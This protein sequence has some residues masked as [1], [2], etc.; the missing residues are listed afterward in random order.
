MDPG[1]AVAVTTLS[2]KYYKNAQSARDEIKFFANELEDFGR[3]MRKFPE[4]ADRSSKLPM[5]ASLDASIRQAFSDLKTLESK[6]VPGK[7]AKAMRRFGMRAWKWPFSKSEVEQWVARFQR[8][9]EKANFA[10]NID[11]TPL[12]I[13]VNANITELQQ[14]QEASEQERLLAKLPLARNASFDS[15]DRQHESLCIE[16]TRVELLQRLRDWGTAHP[17]P[18]YWLSGM[19]GT[20]KSTIARTLAHYFQ[21]IGTLGGSFFFSRSSGEAN[22]AV[23]FVGTL[24]RHLA[25]RSLKLR[26]SV[27][28]AISTHEDVTRQGLRNQW[29]ELILTPLSSTRPQLEGRT[30]LNLVI[31]ALDE[32]GSDEDIETILQLCVEVKD[33]KEVDLGIFITSRPEVTIRLGF[34]AIPDIIHQKLDLRDMPRYLVEHDLSVLLEREFRLISIKHKLPGWPKHEEIR[35]LVQQSDCLF[36]YATTACRY[37]G[38]LDKDPEERLSEVLGS[39]STRGGNTA[40][41]DLMY[42]QVLTSSLITDRS[43]T[44]ITETCDR[45]KQV[46]GSIVTLFD[47]FSIC[48]L[49]GL[50]GV[51]DKRVE[52]SLCRLHSVL[53]IPKDVESSIRLLHPSFRDYLLDKKRSDARFC[54]DRGL[55]HEDLAKHCLRVMSTGLKRNMGHLT[56]PGSPPH[57]AKREHLNTQ[58]PKHVQYACQYWV[59]HLKDIKADSGTKHSFPN[60]GDIQSFFQKD[61][62]HWLEAMSLMAKMS[63]AVLLITRLEDLLVPGSN[64]ILLATVED[65]RRFIFSNRA[66]IEKAPLQTYASALVFCPK[67]S[68]VR[69]WY[70]DQLPTWLIRNPAVEDRWGNCVQTLDLGSWTGYPPSM[71]FSSDGKYLASTLAN[72]ETHIWK[73]ATGALHSTLAGYEPEIAAIEFLQNGILASIYRDGTLRMF[74]PVTGVICRIIERPKDYGVPLES[75]EGP[76]PSLSILPGGDLAILS[77]KGDVWIWSWE[78][79]SWL[80]RSIP[81]IIIARLCGCL[82]DGTLVVIISRGV[83]CVEVCLWN[84]LTDTVQSLTTNSD[85]LVMGSPWYLRVAVSSLNVIAWGTE[86]ESIEL[87]DAGAGSLSELMQGHRRCH[88]TAL[89]FSPDGRS[90]VSGDSDRNLRLW[91]LSMQADSL[92]D[93]PISDVDFA[94]FSPDGTHL[95]AMSRQ[96]GTIQLYSFPLKA[97]PNSREAKKADITSI[98]ISPTGKQVAACTFGDVI[99]IYNTG[100]E[101]L[102]HSL[103]GHLRYIHATAFSQDGQQLASASRDKSIRLWFPKTGASGKVVSGIP[104]L[105]YIRVLTFS[106]NGKHLVS[107]DYYGKTLLLDAESGALNH[108]FELESIVD[109]ITFSSD[110][111]KI[112]CAG[113]HRARAIKV[114]NTSTGNLLHEVGGSEPSEQLE[115]EVAISPNGKYL[116]Y[117]LGE[118]VVIYGMEAEEKRDLPDALSHELN[119]SVFSRDNKSLATC[120]HNGEIKLWDVATAQLIGVSPIEAWAR[121]LSFAAEGNFLESEYGYIPIRYLQD[122]SSGDSSATLTH[123]RYSPHDRW[124]MEGARKMLWIPP[125]YS[126]DTRRIA[127]YAGLF[128]F[129]HGSW[130]AFLGLK[131]GEVVTDM[132]E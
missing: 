67:E 88:V 107:G 42:M 19:A 126:S 6:L 99:H 39:G 121:R 69:Q 23:N 123:W 129:T 87:Y 16:D 7:G 80:K 2:A 85:R 63:Q 9:E 105:D 122:N 1:T 72:G 36:I 31:D 77:P 113:S 68:F 28:E 54:V 11:L 131:Q 33:L 13:D 14:G 96:N 128:A 106:P 82:S 98:D 51:S 84:S 12:V 103:L 21:S 29:K 50:L 8:L 47:E 86:E 26:R 74:D 58:L 127:H 22:N 93:T 78:R 10:L 34:D 61:F 90:L 20:G 56:T 70:L 64:D 100:S 27:C 24:A 115:V 89:R 81:G 4:M 45:F 125:A 83:M 120:R 66:I 124:I 3:L 108:V 71:A 117:S 46:V 76:V 114:W 49:A 109:A 60:D 79:N 110:G 25:N 112:A 30:T 15:W 94:A 116:S 48:G 41:L 91:D 44:D 32:C 38:E 102:E 17:K 73:T 65:A 75:S 92:V 104:G 59:D 43:E 55:K 35:S 119:S 18:L 101:A 53:N 132:Q 37:I 118:A 97:E 95:A 5:A 111:R 40:R 57:D 62:L 130:I 52:Q